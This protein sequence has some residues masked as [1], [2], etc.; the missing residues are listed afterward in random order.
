MVVRQIA[1]YL[2]ICNKFLTGVVHGPGTADYQI[3]IAAAQIVRSTTFT[4]DYSTADQ[5]LSRLSSLKGELK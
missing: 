4:R 5:S 2:P 3:F 1:D